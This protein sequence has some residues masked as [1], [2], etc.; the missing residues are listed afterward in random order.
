VRHQTAH[1]T[2]FLASRPGAADRG[3]AADTRLTLRLDT[4]WSDHP[5][6]RLSRTITLA[7]CEGCATKRNSTARCLPP[8]AAR[9]PR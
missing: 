3:R 5:Y 1:P 9:C 7:Y 2:L 4:P 8:A 6:W